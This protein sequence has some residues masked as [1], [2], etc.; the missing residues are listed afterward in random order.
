MTGCVTRSTC[1]LHACGAVK[2]SAVSSK[3]ASKVV[4]S[5]IAAIIP[6]FGNLGPLLQHTRLI[7]S[8]ALHISWNC[9]LC[10]C[11][12]PRDV[13]LKPGCGEQ[14]AVQ[15]LLFNCGG[16]CCVVQAALRPLLL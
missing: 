8:W 3:P 10:A 15:R 4:T 1:V 7:K 2:L 11:A 9:N 6:L 16:L 14:R 5:G 12:H 13:T